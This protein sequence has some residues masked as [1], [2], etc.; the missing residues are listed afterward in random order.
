LQPGTSYYYQ[1]LAFNASG[2]SNPSSP[3]SATTQPASI[4]HIGNLEGVGAQGRPGRWDAT[5]T[6]TVHDPDHQVVAGATVSGGWSGGANGGGT[7]TTDG[8]G[9][10]TIIKT[11]IKT[12]TTSVAFSVTDV[13]L[14]G[15]AYDPTANDPPFDTA[16]IT[17][18]AP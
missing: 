17:I 6:V 16:T 13:S 8:S 3:A 11:G 7:C 4:I 10:C 12:S 1:V 15:W 14:A 18:Y 2:Y 5:V 9:I